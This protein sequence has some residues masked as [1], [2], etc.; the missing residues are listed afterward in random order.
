MTSTTST[1]T[2]PIVKAQYEAYPYPYRDPKD[3]KKRLIHGTPSSVLQIMHYIFGGKLPNRK[4]RFLTAG[5]GTGD[6]LI[7]MAQQSLNLGLEV[8]VTHLDISTASQA[9]AKQRAEVRELKNVRFI[10]DSLLNAPQYGP[11]DYIDCCGVLHHLDKPEE[12]LKALKAAL[13]PEGGMGIM[14]Y[15][16]L[17][18]TGVYPM[19]SALRRLTDGVED[20]AEKVKIA[21]KVLT[22]MPDSNWL[23]KNPLMTDHKGTDAGVYDLLLHSTDRAYTVMEFKDFVQSAGLEVIAFQEKIKYD[24]RSYLKNPDLLARAPKDRFE[25]AALAEEI[26]GILYKH[27]AYLTFAERAVS[28]EAQNAPEMIP[29]YSEYDGVSTG[30]QLKPNQAIIGNLQNISV[31][32]NMPR[33]AG[34]IMQR[35]DGQKSWRDI[36]G[37]LVAALGGDAPSWDKYWADV[38]EVYNGL[39]GINVLMLKQ[40]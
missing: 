33:Y 5:G 17:G 7:M 16:P 26:G 27:I 18:R 8:E 38:T 13:S 6:A 32:V 21:R 4:L 11:F 39:N 25:A 9:I 24:L 22:D 20:P 37:E 40:P 35:I 30:K 34:P 12:G 29:V 28:A 19:Q 2:A 31:A 1:P 3:E 10:N 14:V 36:H 15:A 23:K